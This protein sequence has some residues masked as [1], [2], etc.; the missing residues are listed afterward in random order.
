[1]KSIFELKPS[2]PRY[3]TVWNVSAVFNYLRCKPNIADLSLKDLSPRL[4]FLLL[5]LSGQRCQN[6]YYFAMDNM[7]LSEDKCVFKVTDKVKQTRKGYHIPPIIY[8]RCPHEIRL[9]PVVHIKEY[10]K[11]TASLRSPDCKQLLVSF[12]RPHSSVSKTTIARWCKLLLI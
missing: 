8:E 12:I 7:E 3:R 11:R 9:C 2:L 4:T 10:V 1:M 6:V 5:L